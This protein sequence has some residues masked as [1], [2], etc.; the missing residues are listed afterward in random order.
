MVR[1]YR[2]DGAVARARPLFR[3]L[4]LAAAIGLLVLA[5]LGGTAAVWAFVSR[6]APPRL[7]LG[8]GTAGSETYAF[9][10]AL[11]LLAERRE[12][13]FTIE[14]VE[15]AGAAANVHAVASGNL[16][17]GLVRS[18]LPMESGVGAVAAVFP[19]V[20][21]LVVRAGAQ[22]AT[23]ADLTGKRVAL[24]PW[25][26]G[27]DDVFAHIGQHYG[28]AE[29]DVDIRYL[30]RPLAAASLSNGS[31]DAF[32]DVIA[33]GNAAM[34][35]LLRQDGITLVAI[36]QAEAIQ[37]FAPTLERMVIP[38]GAVVG[39]PPT[40]ADDLH[41]L[42]V[43]TLLVAGADVAPAAIRALTA[44]L[45][46]G[47][48]ALAELH[49]QSALL[50]GAERLEA[51][52]VPAH[53]GARAYYE[54]DEPLFVVEYAEPMAFAMSAAVLVASGLWQVRRWV[55]AKRKNRGDR[56]NGEL[57][58]L[59]ERLRRARDGAELDDLEDRL[60]GIF[61]RVVADIDHDRLA[62]ET[63]PTFDFVWRS[64][65]ELLAS[66]R[67]ELRAGRIRENRHETVALTS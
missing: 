35:R 47:R 28:F 45:Y 44:L 37:M 4:R 31:V 27:S 57:A 15:T 9:A 64:A 18:D 11:S 23:P 38:R 62:T 50:E 1:A 58:Q 26:S 13:G 65:T 39:R 14:V 51:L 32:V 60:Y 6:D 16:Q 24:M 56:Y 40:P 30:S 61:H 43:R 46:E 19:E 17:L 52:G 10:H 3:T 63:L 22:I 2:R 33:L 55:E 54:A 36:D 21:H 59:V 48:A 41:V 42:A 53:P 34:R 5:A 20:L 7:R 66:R 29:G 49:P 8:A 12:P 25:G 67:G